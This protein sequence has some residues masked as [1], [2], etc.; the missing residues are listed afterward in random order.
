MTADDTD[1]FKAA[2]EAVKKLFN[3]LEQSIGAP[4]AEE[5]FRRW[6]WRM[7]DG[8]FPNW[9]HPED[10]PDEDPHKDSD[11]PHGAGFNKGP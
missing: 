1:K 7:L 2:E 6:A 4:A 8:Q 10:E 5:G 11:D 9:R 3:E